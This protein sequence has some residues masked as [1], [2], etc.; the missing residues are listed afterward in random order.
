MVFKSPYPLTVPNVDYLTYIF[1]STVFNP[2]EKVWIEAN[3]PT[4]YITQSRA[5]ELTQRIGAGLQSI[6]ISRPKTESSDRC[7]VLLIS[8]NQIMTP[9]TMYGIINAGGV[10]CTAPTQASSFEIARQIKGCE[11]KLVICSASVL[12][13]VVA[14]VEQ[15]VLRKLPIAIMSS[16]NGRQELRLRD[17]TSL[18]SD[19][20]LEFERI[21]DQQTLTNRVIFLG[22]SSGTTGIPKGC[23]TQILD[24]H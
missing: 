5:L 12:D 13:T 19:I 3:T 21:T 1:S 18:I 23:P 15:S 14:G 10:V 11:P 22:Y 6:G 16:A 4:N 7:V 8:E 24:L 9:V 20:K 17:G 2:D